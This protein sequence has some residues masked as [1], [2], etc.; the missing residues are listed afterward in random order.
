ML[1]EE[2]N[3]VDLPGML[4][5][6]NAGAIFLAGNKQVSKRTK[7]IDL[8]HHFIREF[9]EEKNGVQQGVIFKIGT[10]LNTADIG[11][12]N[13]DVKSFKRHTNE[14]DA[15]MPMLRERVYGKHGLLS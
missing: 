13:V 1:L 2:L 7:H 8:K 11:T 9:T 3:L 15:G 4:F 6:D 12:K 14:L 5:E 10:E